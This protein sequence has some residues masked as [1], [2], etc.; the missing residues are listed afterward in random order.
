MHQSIWIFRIIV[1]PYFKL[2]LR[3]T[4][5]RH[6]FSIH[7][8]NLSIETHQKTFQDRLPLALKTRKALHYRVARPISTAIKGCKFYLFKNHSFFAISMTDLISSNDSQF[9]CNILLPK[10]KLNEVANKLFEILRLM[11]GWS[12][13]N[14]QDLQQKLST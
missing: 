2:F 11:V 1:I 5:G 12:L 6:P 10:M 13:I 7:E 3:G 4:G 14:L 9:S 8:D